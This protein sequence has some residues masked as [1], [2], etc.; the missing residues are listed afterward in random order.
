[1]RRRAFVAAAVVAAL[2]AGAATASVFATRGSDRDSVAGATTLYVSASGADSRQCTQSAPCKTFD[3][4]YR[5]AAPG[6]TVLVQS[7]SY[8]D[9]RIDNDPAKSG[10]RCD[11]YNVPVDVSG[12]VTFQ[13]DA[14]ASVTW[15]GGGITIIGNGV[16]LVGFDMGSGGVAINPGNVCRL[17]VTRGVI[18]DGLKSAGTG[19]YPLVIDA[20][21]Y[22]ADLNGNWQADGGAAIAHSC[23]NGGWVEP[24]HLRFDHGWYHDVV[25]HTV[26]SSE[27]I[28]CIHIDAA[29]Y[30]TISNSRFT[31]CAG[32]NVRISYEHPEVEN[33][34]HYLIENNFF[35][36]V[37]SEQ[38]IGYNCFPIAELEFDGSCINGTSCDSN[39]I[40][41]NTIDGYFHPGVERGSPGFTNSAFYGNIVVGGNDKFHCDTYIASGIAFYNNVFG[42][43]SQTAGNPVVPCGTGSVV[44][45]NQLLSP[46]PPA[47]DFRLASP[48]VKAAGRVPATVVHGYPATDYAGNQ[49]PIRSP[50]DAGAYQWETALMV[51]GKSIGALV[52]GQPEAKALAFYGRPRLQGTVRIG[53]VKL[54]KL[55]YRLHGGG[56][57]L[58]SDGTK[59]VGAGTSS[60]YYT[61]KTGIGVGA[62]AAVPRSWAG[63]SWIAC[64]RAMKRDF[65]GVGVYFV[66]AGGRN[67]KKIASI[68]MMQNPYRYTDC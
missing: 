53:D 17:P 9:Q 18:L 33:V 40:R 44:A 11:G 55:T 12:C 66:P 20:A 14:G 7:G 32:Y 34:S 16:R 64:R 47:Y 48:T 68:T 5:V 65:G 52:I 42:S 46:G 24:T 4:A 19:I 10:E 56:F 30:V 8:P 26:G 60:P 61:T 29:D 63:T 38:Q 62:E 25:Q 41:F 23:Y 21:A 2:L 27:H 59:I 67:G 3:R 49:R 13:P 15:A 57:W 37:C 54:Q 51:L 35:G 1:M 39:I 45:D 31:N 58:F 28:E 22:V 50:L 43:E 36:R 6:D